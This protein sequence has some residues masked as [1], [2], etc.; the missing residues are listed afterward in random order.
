MIEGGDFHSTAS[1]KVLG[2]RLVRDIP[3]F[4]FSFLVIVIKTNRNR[5]WAQLLKS[6]EHSSLIIT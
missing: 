5:P 6:K 2:H 3:G 4:F 1:R